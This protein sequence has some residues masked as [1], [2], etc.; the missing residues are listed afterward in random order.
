[1]KLKFVTKNPKKIDTAKKVLSLYGVE[2][3]QLKIEIPEIQTSDIEESCLFAANIASSYTDSLIITSCVGYFINALNGFPG[4]HT[5]Y[6]NNTLLSEQIL[7]MMK[8]SEDRSFS[9]KTSVCLYDPKS[10]SNKCFISKSFGKISNF[11]CGDGTSLDRIMIRDGQT[12]NQSLYSYNEVI[13]YYSK[14]MS[15]YHDLGKHLSFNI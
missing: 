12:K 7:A 10:Q 9:V 3:E 2:I 15:H 8:D 13:D 1:M 11:A 14:H 4:L 5:S 6:I